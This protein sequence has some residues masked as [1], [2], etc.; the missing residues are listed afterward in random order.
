MAFR[1]TM[2]AYIAAAL[3][4]LSATAGTWPIRPHVERKTTVEWLA[5]GDWGFGVEHHLACGG[6]S[7]YDNVEHKAGFC[8][9]ERTT[10]VNFWPNDGQ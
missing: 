7:T 10:I 8:A 5:R 9:L 4:G 3:S 2:L 6:P 1:R